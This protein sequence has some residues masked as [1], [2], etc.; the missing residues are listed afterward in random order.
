[1]NVSNERGHMTDF[2]DNRR[3]IRKCCEKFHTNKFDILDGMGK[4]L[5]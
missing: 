2:I 3:L 5:E 1:M 4:F